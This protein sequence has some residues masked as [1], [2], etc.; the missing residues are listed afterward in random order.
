MRFSSEKKNTQ[1]VDVGNNIFKKKTKKTIVCN[2]THQ[3]R[4][5]DNVTDLSALICVIPA[6]HRVVHIIWVGLLRS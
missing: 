1:G 5:L 4:L 3:M 6:S 2:R